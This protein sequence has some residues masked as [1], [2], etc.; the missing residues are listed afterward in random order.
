[1]KVLCLPFVELRIW[2]QT[3]VDNRLV[4]VNYRLEPLGLTSAVLIYLGHWRV[5]AAMVNDM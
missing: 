3:D 4:T 1:M 5:P 2:D